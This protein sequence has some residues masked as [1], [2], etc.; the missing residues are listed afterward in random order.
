MHKIYEDKGKFDL[1]YQIPQIIYSSLI[2]KIID[3]FI[4]NLALSQDNI[5]ELK[6]LKQNNNLKVIQNKLLRI[7]KNKICVLFYIKFYNSIFIYVLFNMFLWCIYKYSNS[8]YKR[9]NYEFNYI[10][11]NTFYFIFNTRN[12]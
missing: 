10:F 5:V 8:S 3:T 11:S 4:K 12:I 2:S 9:F 7:L 1:I 6:Q